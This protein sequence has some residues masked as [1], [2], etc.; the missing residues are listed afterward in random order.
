MGIIFR[1]RPILNIF[2]DSDQ[3]VKNYGSSNNEKLWHLANRFRE[4]IASAL[5]VP[6]EYIREDRVRRWVENWAKAWIKPEYWDEVLNGVDGN[7]MENLGFEIG[8]ILA[9]ARRRDRVERAIKNYSKSMAR[10]L[11]LPE[12]KVRKSDVVKEYALSII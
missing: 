7:K 9:S 10:F 8:S 1:R 5:G 3:Q 11:G 4:G 2:T 6:P 12:E